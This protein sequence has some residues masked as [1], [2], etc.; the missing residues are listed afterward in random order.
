MLNYQRVSRVGWHYKPNELNLLLG[1]VPHGGW[2]T[3]SALCSFANIVPQHLMVII[4]IRFLS[5]PVW[6]WIKAY[7]TIFGEMNIHR[8][9]MIHH[10][11]EQKA[12]K[13]HWPTASGWS[14]YP[15][16]WSR[17][18]WLQPNRLLLRHPRS[19]LSERSDGVYHIH[20]PIVPKK[21]WGASWSNWHQSL[22]Y[23]W[24]LP[25]ICFFGYVNLILTWNIESLCLH[26]S[27]NITVSRLRSCGKN[28]SLVQW[29]I[30][31][32]IL[33]YIYIY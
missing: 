32:I 13:R 14:P 17:P 12:T 33:I 4:I 30:H 31:T 24:C 7:Y 11:D 1:G 21:S 3:L 25:S 19:E 8:F 18:S 22:P 20:R 5:F 23:D 9:I 27:W 26:G 6:G 2:K 15:A 16:A 29:C 28:R 10:C